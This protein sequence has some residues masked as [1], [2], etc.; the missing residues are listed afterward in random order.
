MKYKPR[1]TSLTAMLALSGALL[2]PSHTTYA[3]SFSWG[4]N[5]YGQL[6][7][8][9]D[10]RATNT[11]G[12]VSN[13]TE[14]TMIDG[15]YL[16][17]V[18]L[19]ADG[20]VWSWGWFR[21]RD[22]IL[23]LG[24]G[25]TITSNIPVP[26][27]LNNAVEV[28][29]GPSF[30]VVLKADGTVWSWG[31]NRFSQLGDGTTIDSP[32][33]V[34]SNISNVIAISSEFTQTMALKADGTVWSW[35]NNSYGQVGVNGATILYTPAQMLDNTDVAITDVKM[36]SA[37]R[38]HSA[39]LK[40]DGTVWVTGRTGSK[41]TY[42]ATQVF[43]L[44]GITKV[45]AG[46]EYTLALKDD[47]T[48][49]AWGANYY[50]SL[51]DGTTTERLT[52]IQVK[53]TNGQYLSGV[54]N[55]SA[56]LQAMAVK[57]DGSVWTWG[58]GGFGE[59]GHGNSAN[60]LLAKK[61]VG[62]SGVSAVAT[63]D[64]HSFAYV[65]AASNAAP[66]AN[67]GT[68]QSSES[69]G[70]DSADVTLNGSGS[71]D[72]DGDTLTYNW[73]WNGGTATGVSPTA[74]FPRGTTLVTLSVD[75]GNGE[76]DSATVEITVVDTTPPTVNA[77][78]DV[79][80]EATVIEGVAFDVLAQSSANDVGCTASL[81]AMTPDFY[82]LGSNN[83]DVTATDCA[84]LTATDSMLLT[85]EDTTAPVL[86]L[87]A[88]V[89]VEATAIS[90]VVATGTATAT[91]IFPVT[92]SSDKP[93]TFGL[94]NTNVN[95]TAT[96]D[97][98]NASNGIQTVTVTDTT[99]PVLTVPA[100]VST[101]ANA[102]LSTVAIGTATATDIFS[103]TVI[104][105][106]PATFPL[107]NT[108]VTYTATDGNGLT[109][110][111]TQTITVVDTTAPVLTLPANVNIE[112]TGAQTPV[113]IGTATATDIFGFAITNDAPATYG[114]GTTVVTWTATD[115]N[116]NISTATQ[117]VVVVD[118]TAPTVTANLTPVSQGDDGDDSD[119]GRFTVDF[120]V[121]DI[122]D[123]NPTVV[124]ELIVAGHATALTVTNGQLIEFEY[125]DEKT[126][127]EVEDG[128]LEIEA[129]SMV[130]RV[131]ATDASGNVTVVEI[132]PQGLTRDNDDDHDR[133]DDHDD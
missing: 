40:T 123:A 101:E 41:T 35:G 130:L 42:R 30:A 98:G 6:G 16:N 72:A 50:G 87:P 85:V 63:G 126:E 122:V 52:P 36:I 19:K 46:F 39:V 47:G 31:V 1:F 58:Y 33:P 60:Q 100:N 104:N 43:G 68:N 75:D 81:S 71:N 73:S 90:S 64:R 32:I 14:F 34:Q 78:A 67:A 62:L 44:S 113:A 99:A 66:S 89:S 23:S 96:D 21:P 4:N 2:I 105:D 93:A 114:L 95:W 116:G 26:V 82:P 17:S 54:T 59:L 133:N 108:V 74:S 97:N 106:A 77:G 11:P 9:T 27:G 91:D 25:T 51:G 88:D 24:D 83:V 112:A 20:T 132:Q 5:Y 48:V 7:N 57:D 55:I 45:D 3:D 109:S 121:S 117:N 118:T 129:P 69:T 37:G 84:N 115:V 80:L 70:N 12:L 79:T 124:A 13:G 92:I 65:G 15:N 120:S 111:A 38:Y 128:L 125:E 131:T 110:T 94:N 76:T 29:I 103:A 86:T 10:I 53:D 102:V 28:S 18:G 22:L 119:E 8:G 61:I 56:Y 49:W 107:G 127:I